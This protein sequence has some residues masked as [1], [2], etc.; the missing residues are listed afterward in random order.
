MW[1]NW[2]C[3]HSHSRILRGLLQS[4]HHG[5]YLIVIP[6]SKGGFISCGCVC[7]MCLYPFQLLLI[8]PRVYI[9]KTE[10]KISDISTIIDMLS[11]KIRVF[12]HK[13]KNNIKSSMLLLGSSSLL[14]VHLLPLDIYYIFSIHIQI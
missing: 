12:S 8:G 14:T 5:H 6:H 10:R 4:S 13:E 11:A 9:C 3:L 2:K 7:I 1:V